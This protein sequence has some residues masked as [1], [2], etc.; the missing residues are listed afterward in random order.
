MKFDDFRKEFPT[1]QTCIEHLRDLRMTEGI[2]CKKCGEKTPH[3]WLKSVLKFQCKNCKS[4]TNLKSGTLFQDSNLPLMIWY[5]VLFLMTHTKKGYSALEIQR[6]VGHSRYEPIWYMCQK[7]RKVMGDRD[8]EY[9]LN[10]EIEIDDAFF[11]VV[12]PVK[13]KSSRK[14]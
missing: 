13:K 3:Y 5:E 10:N 14:V 2:C 12:D 11:V 6:Q 1:E 4:R 8:L 7:I 9:N